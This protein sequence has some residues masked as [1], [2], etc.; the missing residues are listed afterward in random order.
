MPL[1]RLRD[2]SKP[3]VKSVWPF[4]SHVIGQPFTRL[5]SAGCAADAAGT[6]GQRSTPF[7]VA[8][9]AYQAKNAATMMIT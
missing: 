7:F 6:S 1:T 9:Q 8:F 4:L 5:S 2:G 3:L